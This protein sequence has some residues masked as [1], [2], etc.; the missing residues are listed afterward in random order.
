MKNYRIYLGIDVAKLTLD[1]CLVT[2]DHQL[3]RGQIL[4]TQKSLNLFLKDLK[5]G[6][7]DLKEILF[8]FEN[9]GI[10]SSLLSMVLSESELH[11]AQVP[12]LEIKRSLGITRGKSDKVDAK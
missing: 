9:T 5:K 10:Y 8:V 7:H 11:Y 4:N 2:E 3:E 1:Y 6:G 12:A